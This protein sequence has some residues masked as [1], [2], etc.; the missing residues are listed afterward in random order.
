MENQQGSDDTNNTR[1]KR[2]KLSTI[3]Y[4][5][6]GCVFVGCGPALL[7]LGKELVAPIIALGIFASLGCV[8]IGL[9]KE[10]ES[11]LLLKVVFMAAALGF[12]RACYH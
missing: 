12:L 1:R 9:I 2:L 3:G 10:G 5:I 7:L 6:F 4:I 11:G 8:I